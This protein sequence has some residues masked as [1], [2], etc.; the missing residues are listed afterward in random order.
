MSTYLKWA[1]NKRRIVARI[2]AELPPGRRL[3]EPFVGS[4]AVFLH[5]DYPCYLLADANGDLINL[6]RRLQAEG[7]PFIAFCRTFFTPENNRPERYYHFRALFNE[8]EDLRLKAALFLYLNRHGYNGLCRYN[9]KGGFNVPFGRYRRPYFPAEEMRAFHRK[10]QHGVVFRQADYLTV[11]AEAGAGDVV[12]CDPPYVP[13]STTAN[14]TSYD[15]N[16]FSMA[17]QERLAQAA[18]AAAARGAHVVISNHC[19]PVTLALYAGAR[20]VRFP[21]SR[22]IS[23]NIHSRN[24]VT[25]LLAVFVGAGEE[26]F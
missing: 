10:S 26:E 7:E 18:R 3:L 8:T 11:L 19:T 25:E 4:G 23:A 2:Q 14:F 1:G 5:T 9:A 16:G 17:D 15:A 13:L 12:Y 21:V 20:I 22:T 6:H 24:P